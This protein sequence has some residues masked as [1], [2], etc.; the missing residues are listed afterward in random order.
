[1]TIPFRLMTDAEL[2]AAADASGSPA[3]IELSNRL[4]C[5]NVKLKM[6]SNPNPQDEFWHT[7]VEEIWSTHPL[8][9]RMIMDAMTRANST[10]KSVL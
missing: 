7:L 1:M 8:T 2:H 10:T 9:R 3:A 4:L 5:A 6:L